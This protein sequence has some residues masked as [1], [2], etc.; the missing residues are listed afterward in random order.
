MDA[1]GGAHIEAAPADPRPRQA[2]RTWQ[3]S[4]KREIEIQQERHSLG[5]QGSTHA[6]HEGSKI[7]VRPRGGLNI[8]NIDTTTVAAAIHAAAKITS[9]ES[10]AD[11]IC[12]NKQQ[13]IMV[14]C[15]PNKLNVARCA[16]IQEISIRG[17]PYEVSSYR[18]A[19]HDTVKGVIGGISIDASTDELEKN[20]VN[21][22]N[23]IGSTT[24]AIMVFQGPKRHPDTV[25][26]LQ[27]TD[28]YQQC[29]RVVHRKDVCPTPTIKTW[30]ACGLANPKE[31]HRSRVGAPTGRTPAAV[32]ERFPGTRQAASCANVKDPIR[33]PRAR[34]QRQQLLQEKPQ[35]ENVTIT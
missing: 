32:G 16:K 9:E 13:N 18:T 27:E 28:V 11:P 34:I 20:V 24:T 23:Q 30:L 31:D 1:R 2:R 25:P 7:V 17:K 4:S 8:V 22:R 21:E 5:H 10:T 14:V 15:T 12:P 3:E 6:S 19:P 26:R 35:H 33:E 29:S